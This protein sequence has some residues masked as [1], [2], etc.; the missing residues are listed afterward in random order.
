MGFTLRVALE[1]RLAAMRTLAFASM[2][3]SRKRN[4]PPFQ[5]GTLK[6]SMRRAVGVNAAQQRFLA[7]VQSVRFRYR[8][9]TE[10]H[11]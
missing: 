9:K 3:R 6:H 1:G 8:G 10:C 2:T 4:V 11:G 5:G 7:N